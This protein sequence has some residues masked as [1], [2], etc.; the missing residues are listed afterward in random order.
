MKRAFEALG[1]GITGGEPVMMVK[2]SCTISPA[3]D[4][5]GKVIKFILYSLDTERETLEKL[6]EA[7]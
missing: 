6:A 2:E 4:L 5:L 1:T 7:P 3:Q